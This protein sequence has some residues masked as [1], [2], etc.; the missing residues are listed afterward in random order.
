LVWTVTCVD[1]DPEARN[2]KVRVKVSSPV[3]PV[4]PGEI[5]PGTGLHE[6][7]FTGLTVAPYVDEGRGRTRLAFSLRATG[8]HGVGRV[9]PGGGSTGTERRSSGADA[10]AA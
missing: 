2:P 5:V 4:L 9:S 6:V 10:K 8:V 1:R 3:Q 7:Q